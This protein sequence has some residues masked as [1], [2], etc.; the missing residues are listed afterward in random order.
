MIFFTGVTPNASKYPGN[1]RPFTSILVTNTVKRR[2]DLKCVR[3]FSHQD[4]I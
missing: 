4:N 2:D 1:K 3:I